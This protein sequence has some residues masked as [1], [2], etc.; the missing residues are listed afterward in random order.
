MARAA[1][2]AKPTKKAPVRLSAKMK[3]VQRDAM[4]G[5]EPVYS[6]KP[7]TW[8]MYLHNFFNWV[9]V[10]YEHADFK[11]MVIQYAKKNG[12]DHKTLSAVP[13]C[14]FIPAGKI[15]Y[16]LNGGRHVTTHLKERFQSLVETLLSYEEP[17]PLSEASEED[18]ITPRAKLVLM[19]QDSYSDL[20]NQMKEFNST[21]DVTKLLSGKTLPVLKM[22][23]E[24]Y[25]DNLSDYMNALDLVPKRG[26]SELR[27]RLKFYVEKTTLIKDAINSL[28]TSQENVKQANRIA[29][30]PKT[31]RNVPA[32][33]IVSKMKYRTSDP[34]LGLTSI[35][36]EAIIG[37]KAIVVFNTKTRKIGKFVARLETGLSVKGTTIE[38]FDEEKSLAKT[39]R[40][41]SEQ[42]SQLTSTT[43]KRFDTMFNEIKAVSTKLTGRINE[44]IL[45][46]KAYK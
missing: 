14:Y 24:H 42:I 43:A 19:Y 6:G 13:S 44:D 39:I 40:K 36:P 28:V 46:L 3:E 32:S 15:A 17:K 2:L 35:N 12:L 33:K 20:D 26:K 22:L 25:S 1:K 30:K 8:N 9:N 16:L 34:T 38:N 21:D 31:K 23:Q 41:P 27:E 5:E 11:D 18:K 7:E 4:Y 45:I 37:A 29:R 10:Q